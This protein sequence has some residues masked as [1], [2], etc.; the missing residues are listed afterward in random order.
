MVEILGVTF[1]PLAWALV[2]LLFGAGLVLL[3]K[4]YG[5]FFM[6]GRSPHRVGDA[7]NV[8]HAEVTEWSGQEGY[9]TA[10]GELWRA[11]SK[12]ELKPGDEVSVSAMKGLVLQVEKKRD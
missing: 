11:V 3:A 10:G 2:T 7:M 9:V 6:N 4:I 5:L 8:D 12:S 1:T